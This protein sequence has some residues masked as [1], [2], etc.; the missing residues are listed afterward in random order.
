MAENKDIKEL[1]T[2]M[3]KYWQRRAE[4]DYL[5]GEKDALQVA[6]EL[7]ANY[8]I[9][10][11]EI[12]DVINQF[13]ADYAKD[14]KISLQEANKILSNSE[15]KSF[16][17][18]MQELGKIYKKKGY[19]TKELDKLEVRAKITRLEELQAQI[20]FKLNEL[21]NMNEEQIQELLTNTFED[22]YYKTVYNAEQYKGFSS[23]FSRMNADTVQKAVRTKYLGANYSDRIW[24]NKNNL[25][26][27]LNQ[28]IPRGLTLG[29]NPRKLADQVSTKLNT[30]YNSTVR[31]IRTEYTKTLNDSTL[32]GYR[33]SGIDKYKVLATLDSRTC[34]I[35]G[36]Y[37]DSKIFDIKDAEVGINMP[38]FHS[39]C[40]CTTIPYF[41]PDE[42]DE[43]TEVFNYKSGIKVPLD[44]TFTEWKDRLH[45]TQDNKLIYK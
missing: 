26:I 38:P 41:E 33:A 11:K 17:K 12:K 14:N 39:N 27:T 23:S 5:A 22:N 2:S 7:K 37:Y 1:T 20:N 34:D 10:L 28:E 8:Q 9:C 29:Y 13:Y 35:C 4:N 44:I 6:K 21:T 16:K 30:N 36:I 24:Q 32:A 19:N 15:L 43:D 3:Q 31:L 40:R 45:K 42:F 25:M 18:Q